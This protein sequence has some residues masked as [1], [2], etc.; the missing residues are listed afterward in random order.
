MIVEDRA[1]VAAAVA[2]VLTEAGYEVVDSAS[3]LTDGIAR[4]RVVADGLAAAVLDIELHGESVYPLVELLDQRAIPVVFL[5]GYGASAIPARWQHVHRVEK[6]FNAEDLLGAV[7]RAI[8]RLPAGNRS[9]AIEKTA[10]GRLAMDI[11]RDTRD[12][13]TEA[14]AIREIGRTR[15]AAAGDDDAV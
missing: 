10:R 15:A 4:F 3:T 9:I 14:R 5:T 1:L 12:A 2:R 13:I 6:P 7:G 11:V 8:E